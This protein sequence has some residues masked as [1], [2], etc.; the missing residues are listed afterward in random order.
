MRGFF[1]Y[2]TR[3]MLFGRSTGAK[4]T[5]FVSQKS[6]ATRNFSLVRMI[7]TVKDQWF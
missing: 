2:E 4:Q 5:Q 7:P 3:E 6:I 1:Q